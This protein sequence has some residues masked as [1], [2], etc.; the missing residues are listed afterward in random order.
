M[1]HLVLAGPPSPDEALLPRAP[2]LPTKRR[3]AR[4]WSA[5]GDRRD[6]QPTGQAVCHRRQATPKQCAPAFPTSRYSRAR[7]VLAAPPEPN[8]QSGMANTFHTP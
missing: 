2:R 6:D 1:A 5:G 7:V 3:I 8:R 4:R